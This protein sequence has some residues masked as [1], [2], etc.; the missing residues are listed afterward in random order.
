[1]SSVREWDLRS[2]G[3]GPSAF[4]AIARNCAKLQKLNLEGEGT[5]E[6]PSQWNVRAL[7]G[8]R[9]QYMI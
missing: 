2:M 8:G 3:L 7:E 5:R 1:M 9:V 4:K 6:V